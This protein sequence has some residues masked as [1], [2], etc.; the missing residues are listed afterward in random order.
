MLISARSW[1]KGYPAS[2][3]VQ[4]VG[5]ENTWWPSAW[6]NF[7]WLIIA[8][9]GMGWSTLSHTGSAFL[10]DN[11]ISKFWLQPSFDAA[12]PLASID[13]WKRFHMCTN[14]CVLRHSPLLVVKLGK[15]F[16]MGSIYIYVYYIYYVAFIQWK[17]RQ[18][19]KRRQSSYTCYTVGELLGHV[20]WNKTDVKGQILDDFLL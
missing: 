19:L 17:N 3:A 5:S 1:T 7:N 4:E 8:E 14:I 13:L 9:P 18:W 6:R 16:D 10:G 20:E 11:M 15:I 12:I 2:Q